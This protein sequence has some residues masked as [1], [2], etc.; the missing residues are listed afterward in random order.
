MIEHIE[1]AQKTKTK[2]QKNNKKTYKAKLKMLKYE[3]SVC[4]S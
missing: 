2:Q 1:N 4:K 3:I